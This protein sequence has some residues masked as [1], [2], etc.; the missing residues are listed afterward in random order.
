[1]LAKC[2]LVVTGV[3]AKESCGAEQLCS[4][5]EAGIEGEIHVVRLLWQHHDQEE[6]WGFLLIDKPN[7]F[8][9]DNRTAMMWEVRHEWTNGAWFAFN[10]YRHWAKLVIRAGD[11][12]GHFL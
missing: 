3:E 4:G 12:T 9:E 1:M 2:V 8:N 10:C 7:V 11:G 6:E 5:L